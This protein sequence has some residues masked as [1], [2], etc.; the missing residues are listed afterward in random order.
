MLKTVISDYPC[1]AGIQ[2][3]LL[4]KV[5]D[6]LAKTLPRD[7]KGMEMRA[8]RYLKN[9]IT[10]VGFVEELQSA[11][12]ELLRIV[13]EGSEEAL[14]EVYADFAERWCEKVEDDHLV[15]LELS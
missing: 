10:A 2:G 1:P 12:E 7:P 9:P 3:A 8:Y 4:D 6:V 5:Y 15:R 11:N 14:L 13:G